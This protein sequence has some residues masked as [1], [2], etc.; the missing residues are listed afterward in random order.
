MVGPRGR[1][2]PSPLNGERAGARGETVRETRDSAKEKGRPTLSF[3]NDVLP[4]I[5]KAGCNA[6]S[7]HAKAEGQNGFKLSVFAYD[8]KSD[9]RQITRADRGRRVFPAFPEESLILKKPTLALEH[10]G[11]QRFERG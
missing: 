1:S 8:P 10:E 7:C 3:L 9:Y 4:I 5:G 11:G 2:S 6:G